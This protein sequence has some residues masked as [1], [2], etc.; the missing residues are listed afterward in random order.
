MA[1]IRPATSSEVPA[2]S[3]LARRTWSDAFGQ[4]VDSRAEAIELE[5]TRS[6]AYFIRALHDK[7]ILVA[8]RNGALVGYVQFGDVE[9]PEVDVERGDQAL[10]RLYVESA[11]QGEGVGRE[12]LDAALEHPR[13]ASAR[14][15]YLQVWEENVSAIRLYES[16]GFRTVGRTTFTIGSAQLAEDLVMVLDKRN[17][18]R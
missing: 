13:L 15:I 11:S 4:S 17:G 18:Q 12:L 16:F 7:T 10:Q 9:I 3:A 6:E 8:E 14:R 2:L 5:Q 1:A